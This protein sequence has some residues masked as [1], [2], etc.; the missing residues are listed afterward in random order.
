MREAGAID[1]GN[2]IACRLSTRGHRGL[3]GTIPSSANILRMGFLDTTDR[4]MTASVGRRS[5]A[6]VKRFPTCSLIITGPPEC[7]LGARSQL[8]QS[9]IPLSPM[10]MSRR[11]SSRVASVLKGRHAIVTLLLDRLR[12]L[13]QCGTTVCDHHLAQP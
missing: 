3:F 12:L 10:R 1:F 11:Y 6:L 2:F 4:R 13:L 8:P 7:S 9:H 5:V